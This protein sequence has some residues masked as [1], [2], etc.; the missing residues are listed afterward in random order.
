MSAVYVIDVTDAYFYNFWNFGQLF[1]FWYLW[2]VILVVGFFCIGGKQ[3]V[4][5]SL[6]FIKITTLE[7]YFYSVYFSC[8]FYNYL[9]AYLIRAATAS[10]DTENYFENSVK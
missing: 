8:V 6:E 2:D 1:Y 9:R 7:Q 10:L 5:T 3:L 4:R